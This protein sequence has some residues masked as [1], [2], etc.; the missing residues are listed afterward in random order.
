V[1]EGPDTGGGVAVQAVRRADHRAGDQG[2]GSL[3]VAW[4]SSA[5]FILILIL[6]RKMQNVWRR[7]NGMELQGAQREGREQVA[8][9]DCPYQAS[10][11]KQGLAACL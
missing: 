1:A 6:A 5:R 3:P 8:K 2:R 10:A 11:Q 9:D 4:H 7:I